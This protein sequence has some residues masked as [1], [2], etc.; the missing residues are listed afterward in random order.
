MA[1]IVLSM[2]I[3]LQ[4]DGPVV[5]QRLVLRG[6]TL[7]SLAERAEV[8]PSTLSKAIKGDKK[9]SGPVLSRL[10]VALD[11]RPDELVHLNDSA[12][13]TPTKADQ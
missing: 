2:P 13:P 4:L 3:G 7:T 6:F 5:R 9:V 8:D 11:C 10:A 12:T 1:H